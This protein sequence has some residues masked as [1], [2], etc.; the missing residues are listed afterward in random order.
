MHKNID[1][2][3]LR[4]RLFE[5]QFVDWLVQILVLEERLSDQGVLSLRTFSIS[6]HITIIA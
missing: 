4:V 6:H 1:P 5:I 2:L 3:V